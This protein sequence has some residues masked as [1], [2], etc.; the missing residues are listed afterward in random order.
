MSIFIGGIHASMIPEDVKG[1]FDQVFVGEA[2]SRILGVLSGKIK[3]K[4][5]PANEL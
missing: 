3:D 5:L 2:E 4:K 1:H